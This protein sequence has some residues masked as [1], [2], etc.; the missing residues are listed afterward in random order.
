MTLISDMSQKG[1]SY[2]H[3]MV[4]PDARCRLSYVTKIDCSHST[5]AAAKSRDHYALGPL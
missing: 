4:L 1:F 2:I 3:T 5:A